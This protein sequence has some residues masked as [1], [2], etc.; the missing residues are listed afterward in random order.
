M[1]TTALAAANIALNE[2]DFLV[3]VVMTHVSVIGYLEI[4]VTHS[5]EILAIRKILA[6]QT[7]DEA[8]ARLSRLN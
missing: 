1:A 8:R 2:T 5:K 6:A 7:S 3:N 4:A